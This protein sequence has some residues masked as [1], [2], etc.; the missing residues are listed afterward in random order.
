LPEPVDLAILCGSEQGAG[1]QRRA[2]DRIGRA[3]AA[4][5]FASAELEGMA[6]AALPP[7]RAP[8]AC[9][10]AVP[11]AWASSTPCTRC[12][13]SR[14]CFHDELECGGIT[15]IAQSGSLLQALLFNDERLQF[16]LAVSSGQEL[17]TTTADFM[18]YALQQPS[19]RVI[20][21]ILEGVRDAARFTQALEKARQ[22][23]VPVIAL[24]L[25]RTRGRSG[26]G[27]EPIPE[28]L[29]AMQKCMRLCF[30]TT[31]SS[32]SAIQANSRQPRLC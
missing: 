2:G 19:T 1:A 5:T 3:R 24:K 16:N 27:S 15:C 20:A 28:R 23:D 25:A 26:A 30:S 11:T 31:V 21:L 22:R 18:D 32:V 8:R 7:W 29:R 9:R 10:C 14:R 17:V 4:D 13:H 6:K 12:A